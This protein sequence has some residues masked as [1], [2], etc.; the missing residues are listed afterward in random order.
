MQRKEVPYHPRE[1]PKYPGKATNEGIRMVF[2]DCVDFQ[3]GILS[4]GG[5]LSRKVHMF[6]LIGVVRNE[7]V[8]DYVMRPLAMNETLARVSDAEACEMLIDG[9]L[10]TIVVMREESLD[11]VVHKMV[12]GNIILSFGEGAYFLSCI[13]PTEEKRAVSKPENEPSVKASRDAFVESIR[14]NTAIIRRHVRTPAL[15]IKEKLVGRQSI[16]MVDIVYVDGIANPELVREAEARLSEIDVDAVLE[17][18]SFEEYLGDTVKTPFPLFSYT[19]RSDRFSSALVE[20]RIGMF[21]DGLPF[22]YLIPGTMG[23]LM[24]ASEDKSKNWMEVSFL[25]VLRFLCLFI[26][27]L[28]PAL[29]VASVNFHPEMLPTALAMSIA[30]ARNN[31]PFSTVFEVLLL[32]LAFEALQEAGLRLPPAIGTTVSILG[33][34]VVGSAAVEAKIVSPTVLIVVAAAGIAGYTMPSQELAAALR[35]SRLVMVLG[36]SVGGLFGI[37]FLFVLLVH[38]MASLMSFGVPF[39]TPFAGSPEEPESILRKPLMFDRL[40][41]R[42][43]KT[44]NRRNQR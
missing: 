5:D 27:L 32:L 12:Q 4:L 36:A 30:E 11:D 23:Q 10:Y 24:R 26:A 35:L 33:G 37:T 38:H 20:G 39:L 9:G 8:S 41:E 17:S 21:V 18:G 2:E 28:L 1:S 16:T 3:E 31:V 40:R 22:G 14:T 15:K 6:S 29:Y 25:R 42:S 19:E 7:R 34:L 13:V 44:P 43:L